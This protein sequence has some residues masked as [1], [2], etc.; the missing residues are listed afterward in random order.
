M[1]EAKS[2]VNE[3]RHHRVVGDRGENV[4]LLDSC[5]PEQKAHTHRK[6]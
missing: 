6:C 2:E 5:V 3:H 4:I 1:L